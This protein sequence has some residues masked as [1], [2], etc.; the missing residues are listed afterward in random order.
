LKD[1]VPVEIPKKRNGSN[2]WWICL[3][4]FLAFNQR[5]QHCSLPVAAAVFVVFPFV[6]TFPMLLTFQVT[7]LTFTKA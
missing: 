4:G 7:K 2:I 1:V 5:R 6:L 3:A